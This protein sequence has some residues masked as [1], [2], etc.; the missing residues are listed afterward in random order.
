MPV[1]S[2][3]PLIRVI[4]QQCGMTPAETVIL[5]EIS[6][7]TKIAQWQGNFSATRRTKSFVTNTTQV[8]PWDDR[9]S[10]GLVTSVAGTE[11]P[12]GCAYIRNGGVYVP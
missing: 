9:G 4:Q 12:S 11:V 2:N 7:Y 1:A 6:K 3:Q 5:Q 8:L 10:V